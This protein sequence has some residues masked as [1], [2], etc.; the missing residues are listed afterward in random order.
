[1]SNFTFVPVLLFFV[2]LST[3]NSSF[4]I[5]D[6][7]NSPPAQKVVLE[8][9][10]DAVLINKSVGENGVNV[11]IYLSESEEEYSERIWTCIENTFRFLDTNLSLPSFDEFYVYSSS[12]GVSFS[13]EKMYNSI[14]VDIDLFI[15]DK[16]FSFERG[17]SAKICERYITNNFG[18]D[19]PYW[20]AKGI[21]YYLASRI[22]QDG[23]GASSKVFQFVSYVPV[24]GMLHQH[25]NEIPIIY[26]IGAFEEP[27]GTAC[28]E[29]Y[30]NSNK[31]GAINDPPESLPD[32][33]SVNINGVIKPVLMFLTLEKIVNEEVLLKTFS[34]F[35]AME[36]D[37]ANAEDFWQLLQENTHVDLTYYKKNFFYTNQ[38]F[39][40]KVIS[41]KQVS[42][43]EY[44][45][46]VERLGS[47]SI[48]QDVILITAADTLWQRW[49]SVDNW[50]IFKFITE[51]KVIAAEIDPYRK[52]YFDIN[53]TNNSYTIEPRYGASL[54]IAVRWYFWI[55][56]ALMIIGSIG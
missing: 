2:L 54:S 56:N 46:L 45:V 30:Y 41:L 6:F 24:Y 33:S 26:T 15:P 19:K 12:L 38:T 27:V 20:I 13:E 44:E 43:N 5:R 29:T 7:E 9:P 40:D 52:N 34:Q 18:R 32:D 14:S 31:I 8:V 17:L 11:K 28:L 3:F 47:G 37:S 35:F 39:D 1:M 16:N 53:F 48:D 50:K 49:N 4:L 10:E 23:Y 22:V 25:Y 51:D 42:K 21:P 55:Q 36:S